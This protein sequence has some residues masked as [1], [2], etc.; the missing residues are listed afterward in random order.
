MVWP[1]IH[2]ALRELEYQ[3]VHVPYRELVNG[4][5]FRFL[6]AQGASR[7][8]VRQIRTKYQDLLTGIQAY[9][10]QEGKTQKWLT[11]VSKEYRALVS[12]N[13][14]GKAYPAPGLA[15]Y[16][17][18]SHSLTDGL[19][20]RPTHWAVA[21]AWLFNHGLGRLM[22]AG[23][24]GEIS[25]SWIEDWLMSKMIKQMLADMGVPT[26]QLDDRLMLVKS[27]LR[28]ENWL[29]QPQDDLTAVVKAWF[30]N[31]QLQSWFKVNRYEDVLWFNQEAMNDWLW[32][33]LVLS[34]VEII[35]HEKEDIP[36]KLTA[37]YRRVEKIKAAMASSQYQVEKM[38]SVLL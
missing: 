3:P 11:L 27:L 34:T 17:M 36:K 33:S 35:V 28:K 10:G 21:L 19:R 14:L 29:I 15:Y 8:A 4:G 23:D 6:V 32:W 20:D 7:E 38:M 1:D 30:G 22:D 16:K 26:A 9:L 37:I 25:Q 12:L 2:N 5:M 13:D 31:P 18:L 24:R